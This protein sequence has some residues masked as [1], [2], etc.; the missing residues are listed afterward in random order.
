[1]TD[2]ILAPISIGELFDKI[3]ILEIKRARLEGEPLFHVKQELAA[4]FPLADRCMRPSIEA[5]V[6]RLFNVNLALW[7]IEDEIRVYES[8]GDFGPKFI[9]LARSVYKTNDRRAALKREI[10]IACGSAIVEEKHY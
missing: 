9:E 2:A 10:N 6:E 4:L 5:A 8:I 3:G 1:M 7:N